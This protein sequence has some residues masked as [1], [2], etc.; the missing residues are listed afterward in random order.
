LQRSS[1]AG[2]TGVELKDEA[3]TL[4]PEGPHA[5]DVKNEP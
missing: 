4:A 1:T 2:L 5:I 3:E